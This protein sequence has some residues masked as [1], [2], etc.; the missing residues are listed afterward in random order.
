MIEWICGDGDRIH[1]VNECKECLCH[2]RGFSFRGLWCVRV[3]VMVSR[4]TLTGRGGRWWF[5]VGLGFL[6][7]R[8]V[9]SSH[10]YFG[11]GKYLSRSLRV[12]YIRV[13]GELEW[14]NVL[15][16]G[17]DLIG[18]QGKCLVKIVLW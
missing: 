11:I 17:G 2:R 6:V 10:N 7:V 18:F 4:D 13:R 15:V 8:F 12:L 3:S 9:R 5:R 1:L 16:S 14:C